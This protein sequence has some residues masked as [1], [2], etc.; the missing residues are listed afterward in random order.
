MKK[1]ETMK[2]E[3][4]LDRRCR[5]CKHYISNKPYCELNSPSCAQLGCRQYE[6]GINQFAYNWIY[7]LYSDMRGVHNAHRNLLKH[8]D[9][10]KVVEYEIEKRVWAERYRKVS[11]LCWSIG[12]EVLDKFEEI[13]PDGEST[14]MRYANRRN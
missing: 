7:E 14:F 13:F 3:D 10:R 2:D 5:Q 12:G 8:G 11:Q 4:V 1:V 6:V 9:W